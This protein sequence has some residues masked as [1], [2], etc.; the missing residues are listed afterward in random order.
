MV[1]AWR[2]LSRAP[3]FTL[4]VTVTL[5]LAIGAS[6]AI[7]TLIDQLLLRRL[8]VRQPD[9]LVVVS[10]FPLPWL[11]PSRGFADRLP[12]GSMVLSTSYDT[13]VALTE[14]V[15]AF[16]R[17]LA[18]QPFRGVVRLGDTPLEAWGE[19]V[20]GSYFDML[21]ITPAVG[22]LLGST[23]E[24]PDASPVVVLAH[25]YWQ[26]QFGGDPAA[27]GRTVQI[28]GSAVTI[29]GV[30][31]S[32]F[33]GMGGARSSDFF[34]PLAM[35][36]QLT[37]ARAPYRLKYAG[38]HMLKMMARL[39]P[40]TN[41]EQAQALAE[42]VY[43]QLVANGCLRTQCT[44]KDRQVYARTRFRLL[45][46]GTVASTQGAVTP[47]LVR[48]LQVLMA[49]AVL[50]VVIATSNVTNLILA[51]ELR[52]RRDVAIRYSLGAGRLRM[53]GDRLVE[54]VVLACAAG[55]VSLVIG[56][57][58]AGALLIMLPIGPEHVSIATAPSWRV[59][60]FTACIALAC[61]LTIWIAA[62]LPVTRR[63]TLP[64]LSDAGD[65]APRSALLGVRRGLLVLQTAL[66]LALLCGASVF[67]HSLYNLTS[68]DPGFRTTGL[69]V[70]R[71]QP[72]SALTGAAEFSGVVREMLASVRQA[73]GVQT[74]TATSFVPFVGG[75]GSA[76]VVGGSVP[77]DAEKPVFAT[78]VSAMAGYFNAIGLP[79][80]R[81]REFG[82]Q[83]V[84]EAP[85]VAVISESLARVLFGD[86]EPIG[87]MI[88]P[89][90]G[91]QDTRVV[92]VV[93]D[94]RTGVR[95]PPEPA[96]YSPWAQKPMSWAVM[97]VR[98]ARE[99]QLD[100]SLVRRI[101]ARIDKS[102]AI[103]EFSTLN[104][105]VASSLARD[106]ALALLSAATGGLAAFLCGL[107]LFGLMDYWVTARAREIGV[108]LALGASPRSIQWLMVRE[109]L[110]V[111]LI[112]AAIGLPVYL[113]ASRMLGAILFGVSPIDPAALASGPA[114]LAL[115]A[116][117]A[118]WIPTHQAMRLDP[119]ATLRRV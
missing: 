48:A 49:M 60:V 58:L 37:G 90:Y 54:S 8:P 95:R 88:G 70:F 71:I 76:P 38:T 34:V 9:A 115:V 35:H 62:S 4:V 59:V 20:T 2:R 46:G 106:R 80:V 101:A 86:T 23:D 12:D 51:R 56:G 97:V 110:V 36:D 17:T 98:T 77:A 7:F 44:E 68:V 32:G 6:G 108:R 119:A 31:Q 99:G 13:Y 100:L 112:G 82:E 65:G 93:T 14:H 53:L 19:L 15:A 107:G 39:R 5:A 109:A 42:S 73:G 22:R 104:G 11:G 103:T 111:T 85:P 63:S 116:V 84:A 57:W 41:L 28:A 27:V 45:P 66:S 69:T 40:E 114:V 10:A 30:S 117:A 33:A 50:L 55:G 1:N 47:Q 61:G 105:M 87:Q 79:I 81:G 16:E 94:T 3:G 26:R 83:D 18:F 118:S 67:A 113:T 21:G 92:G 96:M 24:G 91:A 102:L 29:V 64:Q 43:Q 25:G 89:Q 78:Q 74:A 52:H 75:G 72:G